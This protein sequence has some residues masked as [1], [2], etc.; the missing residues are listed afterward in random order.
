[1]KA[2]HTLV[3]LFFQG[4]FFLKKRAGV[5]FFNKKRISLFRAM[6]FLQMTGVVCAKKTF[7]KKINML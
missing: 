5:A 3:L 6:H 7:L 1:M 2:D 4:D